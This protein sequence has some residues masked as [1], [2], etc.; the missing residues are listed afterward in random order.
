MMMMISAVAIS[1]I[2][3]P[4]QMPVKVHYFTDRVKHLRKYFLLLAGRFAAAGFSKTSIKPYGAIGFV[5]I[6]L[7]RWRK[8]YPDA[9][10]QRPSSG[11]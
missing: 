1:I 2:V 7:L 9:L 3:T 11:K 8:S 10:T 6:F 4:F 5:F